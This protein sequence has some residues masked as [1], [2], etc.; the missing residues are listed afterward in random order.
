[1]C[2][3]S[4]L[5]RLQVAV[6]RRPRNAHQRLRSAALSQRPSTPSHPKTAVWTLGANATQTNYQGAHLPYVTPSTSSP[7]ISPLDDGRSSLSTPSA[8]HPSLCPDHGPEERAGLEIRKQRTRFVV[9]KSL[10]TRGRLTFPRFFHLRTFAL[11]LR[12]SLPLRNS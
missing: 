3:G 9:S 1:M 2:P 10:P 8:G 11:S 5:A 7:T 6:E 12:S 4:G